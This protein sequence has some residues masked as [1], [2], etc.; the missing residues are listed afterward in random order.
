MEEGGFETWPFWDGNGG[1]SVKQYTKRRGN[2]VLIFREKN[3]NNK[4]L[5]YAQ[6]WKIHDCIEIF[7]KLQKYKQ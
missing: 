5:S 1:Q 4:T 3:N 2:S 7:W 6:V